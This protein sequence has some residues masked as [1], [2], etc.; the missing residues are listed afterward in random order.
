MAIS[1]KS[2]DYNAR[3]VW[4]G[5]L[6]QGTSSYS[7]YGREYALS[8]S[9]K[10]DLEGSADPMFRGKAEL[11]NPEDLFIAA[12]LSCHMLSYLA[13]CARRG[14]SVTSY[15]DS[16]SGSLVFDNKGGCR[17]ESV[18][19]HPLVTIADAS[20]YD[21]AMALHDTAHEQCYIASS[22]NTAIHHVAVVNV[23]ANVEG[24]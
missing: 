11:Y 12:I 23:E 2:H 21:E 14:L 6:G 7:V 15:E 24:R 17:F 8:I 5:N 1:P 4:T 19:L 18:T 13:L 10:P 3:L 16:A 22:C 20:R 9:G